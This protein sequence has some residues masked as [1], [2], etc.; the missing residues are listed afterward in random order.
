MK[1]LKLKQFFNRITAGRKI[2]FAC[3]AVS[4]FLTKISNKLHNRRWH[5]GI[6]ACNALCLKKIVISLS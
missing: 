1:G 5:S 4:R 3:Y 2:A 6:T